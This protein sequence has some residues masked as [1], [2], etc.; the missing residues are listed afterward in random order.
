MDDTNAPEAC[1]AIFRD[2]KRPTWLEL[3]A[4]QGWSGEG[5][6]VRVFTEAQPSLPSI[7]PPTRKPSPCD[8]LPEGP[9]QLT[10]VLKDIPKRVAQIPII[11]LDY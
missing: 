5:N 9:I 4:K 11:S 2:C 6:G 1:S 3:G 10:S 8:F 7:A